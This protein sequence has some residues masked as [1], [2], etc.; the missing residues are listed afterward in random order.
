MDISRT[1]SLLSHQEDVK[2]TYTNGFHVNTAVTRTE[3]VFL[4]ETASWRDLPSF[5]LCAQ[6]VID[7]KALIPN[8]LTMIEGM[9]TQNRANLHTFKKTRTYM[10]AL[11]NRDYHYLDVQLVNLEQ[12]VRK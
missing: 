7:E 9:Y 10:G 6:P 3:Q 8:Q 11:H 1:L 2:V 5:L 4:D 12:S